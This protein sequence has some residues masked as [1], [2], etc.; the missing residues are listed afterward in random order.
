M[1]AWGE[2]AYENDSACDWLG[3]LSDS[4]R[5][6]LNHAFWSRYSEEGVAAAQVLSDL[7]PKVQEYMGV[8][9]FNEALEVVDRELKPVS[10]SPWDNPKRRE[11]FLRELRRKLSLR[12]KFLARLHK[13]LHVTTDLFKKGTKK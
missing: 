2:K 10:L 11:R 4:L 8:F 1:G 6:T 12:Q 5:F 3:D 9:S 13:R 7:P